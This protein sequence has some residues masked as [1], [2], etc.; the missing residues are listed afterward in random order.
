MSP[1]SGIATCPYVLEWV[2]LHESLCRI[3]LGM[4]PMPQNCPWPRAF[5][6][7]RMQPQTSFCRVRHLLL[8]TTP[9]ALWL[10]RQGSHPLLLQS[11]MQH[12]Q[13]S[14][15]RIG[16]V[17]SAAARRAARSMIEMQCHIALCSWAVGAERAH[18]LPNVRCM[19]A[20]D[21]CLTL[22]LLYR[23]PSPIFNNQTSCR[24]ASIWCYPRTWT[25]SSRPIRLK[26]SA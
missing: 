15:G 24:E 3:I 5:L 16:Q 12:I 11:C 19:G 23:R 25:T 9:W 18:V 21:I 2:K 4:H 13:I 14:Y 10:L 8:I 17:S 22:I 26:S 20:N 7:S 6:G 1:L